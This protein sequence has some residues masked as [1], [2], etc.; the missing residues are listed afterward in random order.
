[1]TKTILMAFLVTTIIFGSMTP[2]VFADDDDEDKKTKFKKHKVHTGDGPPPS[3]LGQVG[4]LYIDSSDTDNLVIYKKTAKKTWTNLGSFQGEQGPQGEKGDAGQACWD[5]NNNGIGDMSE[6]DINGDGTVDAL[7]CKGP[8]GD[9]GDA[10]ESGTIP[11]QTCPERHYVSGIDSDGNLI[12]TEFPKPLL[13]INDVSIPE[14]NDGTKTLVFT[15]SLVPVTSSTVTVDYTT[16]DGTA[17]SVP[18]TKLG[19]NDF[20]AT[21]GTLTIPAGQVSATISVIING[22]TIPESAETFTVEL[23]NPTNA[24][25]DDGIGIGTIVDDDVIPGP[26]G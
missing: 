25:I 7:D 26:G 12:C 22:D 17:L 20:V 11:A 1:M 5:L 16:V 9:K 2:Y 6:E 15:V 21:S 3:G 19:G 14:G 10:G 23:S 13:S 18:G 4:D 8:K 24:V